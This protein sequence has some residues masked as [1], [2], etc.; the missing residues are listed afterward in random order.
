MRQLESRGAEPLDRGSPRPL[1]RSG[2][3]SGSRTTN[4]EQPSASRDRWAWSLALALALSTS[5]PGY[6]GPPDPAG[7]ASAF[8]SHL[9]SGV[10]AFH[11][12]RNRTDMEVHV[13]LDGGRT[14]TVV[15]PHPGE[16]ILPAVS[17]D[18]RQ[19]VFQS[20]RSGRPHLFTSRIPADGQSAQALTTGASFD[21]APT[22]SPDG[23]YV[24][25]QSMRGSSWRICRI[26]LPSG[27]PEVI[28]TGGFDALSP[29]VSTAGEIA[30]QIRHPG[31]TG[32]TA[33]VLAPDGTL[34]ET[35]PRRGELN[36]TPRFS[37]DGRAI[38]YAAG[39]GTGY[40]LFLYDRKSRTVRRL[41]EDG[42]FKLHPV[43]C[44]PGGPL[45]FDTQPG[46][47][48]RLA[49]IQPG[50]RPAPVTLLPSAGPRYAPAWV[51]R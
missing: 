22:F 42:R 16:D 23:R 47:G 20:N 2:S 37:P 6:A 3:R 41:T 35:L 45:L 12:P 43:F 28:T 32:W 13:S 1:P 26:E 33:V 24:Y 51:P 34:R 14:T 8:L 5:L 29:S 38:A 15:A 30:C 19:I 11:A 44:G 31:E 27:E 25:F 48:W 17:P 36:E 9:G 50:D 7:E 49:V 10:L 18:G 40:D 21:E 46:G 39:T 4:P